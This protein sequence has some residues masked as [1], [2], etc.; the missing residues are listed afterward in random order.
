MTL[1]EN[2]KKAYLILSVVLV[3]L[4]GCASLPNDKGSEYM[5]TVEVSGDEGLWRIGDFVD[6][7]HNPTGEHYIYTANIGT[8]T[9]SATNGSDLTVTLICNMN[10]VEL[11]LLEYGS[12][13]ISVIDNFPSINIRINVGGETIDLGSG[14]FSKSTKRITIHNVYPLFKALV[15]NKVV[16]MYIEINDYG[17]STYLFDIYSAGFEYTYHEAFLK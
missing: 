9:N 8:F 5:K 6:E 1:E 17:K 4:V 2:M 15:E 3:L 7:F 13:P 10:D 11:K 14:E 16:K 12:F